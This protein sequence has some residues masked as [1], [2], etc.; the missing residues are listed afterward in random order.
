MLAWLKEMESVTMPRWKWFMGC[1]LNGIAIG[2]VYQ[3]AEHDWIGKI[4]H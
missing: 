3:M 4:L 2:L 1:L